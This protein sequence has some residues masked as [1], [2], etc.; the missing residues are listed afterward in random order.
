MKAI[1]I[2]SVI[3]EGQERLDTADGRR[4]VRVTVIR[5]GASINGYYYGEPAL[6]A[7]AALIENAHAY[8]DHARSEADTAV[9]SVRDMVGFYHSPEY[10]QDDAG[11]DGRGRVD[12]T[13]HILESAD[14]LWSMIRE[15]VT[16]GRPELIGLSIDIYGTWQPRTDVASTGGRQNNQKGATTHSHAQ[17]TGNASNAVQSLKE[18]TGVLALNSCDVVTRPSAGGSFQRVLQ[19][20]MLSGETPDEGAMFMNEQQQLEET[21]GVE[22]G[23]EITEGAGGTHAPQAPQAPQVPQ[24]PRLLEQ[25]IREAKEAQTLRTSLLEELR[26]ERAQLRLERRLLEAALPEA[27]K[28][29]L[30]G[31]Y[32]GRVFE[33]EELERDITGSRQ[34]L[35]ELSAQG[36]VRGHGHEKV[37]LAMQVTEAEKM[38]AAF[39]GMLGLEIDQSRFAGVR[40]FTSIREAYARVTGDASVSGISERSQVGSIRVSESAPITRITEADTTTASFSYLLGTSMNKRLLKDYQAWPAEWM[41]FAS[42]VPIKDF[43]QQSRV[44][45]GAFGSLPVV[46]E[47]T[48]Y[49]AITLTDTAATYVPQKRGNLVTACLAGNDWATP[50]PIRGTSARS[51]KPA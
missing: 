29:Q 31:R 23:R 14:W 46:A 41:K 9:R 25:E 28:M 35:A 13:L 1:R 34:M 38:Q 50:R 7:I 11:G 19:A 30:H 47:D 2:E 27:I 4:E 16:L 17:R 21:A 22:N 24:A 33:M 49:S 45:L 32:A 48:A 6:R 18:V 15:A 40:G 5:G 51:E 12:A 43:K 3:C 37:E 44:R 39:D 20:Q 26:L 36:L 42:I 8:V 10:V